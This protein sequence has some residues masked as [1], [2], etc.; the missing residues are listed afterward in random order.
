[1]SRCKVVQIGAG[2]WGMHHVHTYTRIENMELAAICDLNEERL[3]A[4]VNQYGMRGYTDYQEMLTK[5]KPDIVHA[6][7]PPNIPRHIW[8]EP[9]A[10]AGAKALVIDKPLALKPLEA[11]QLEQAQK[12]TGL[13]IIVN[14]QRRYFE[15]SYKFRELVDNGQ[16]G[17]IHFVR[18]STQGTIMDM[19]T[20]MMDLAQMAVGDAPLRAVWASVEG[21][22]Y[23]NPKLRCPESLVATYT[24]EGGTRVF[25][26]STI[27][28]FG[29]K[30]FP[31]CKPKCSLDVWG[32]KG[33]YWKREYGTWGYQIEGEERCFSKETDFDKDAHEEPHAAMAVSFMALADWVEDDSKPHMG[34]LEVAKMGFDA[35]MS[36]YRSA[37]LSRRLSEP[38][39]S[40]KL[41]EEEWEALRDR[42]VK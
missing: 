15:S 5:E 6:I 12:E 13:K 23:D 24:F 3:S 30:D 11:D 9:V 36:A 38:Q 39:D 25:F 35:I 20:H 31:G 10:D 28:A 8:V 29:S 14:H 42:L 33:R 17:D 1:M 18:A 37:L 32:T 40:L 7:T 27:E 34:R 21:N 26:E 19:A 16:L 22:H 4:A 41:S 2:G